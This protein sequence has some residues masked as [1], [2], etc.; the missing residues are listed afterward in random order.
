MTLKK[1]AVLTVAFVSAL[2]LL[3]VAATGFVNLG[4]ANPYIRD[5]K[6]EGTV[7]P[8]DGTK[9][10]AISISSPAN[11]TSY[12][13][14]NFLLNFSAT[15]ER[16]NNISLSLSE[17]YYKPSWQNDRTNIDFISLWVKNNYT[18]P[19]TFS[20]NMTN[21]PEGPHWLEVCAAATAFAYETRHE[22]KGVYY[23]TY[24][25]G[26][27]VSSSSVVEFTI[28]TI[29]PSILSLSVENKT[30]VASSV[31]L[32]L[33]TNEPVSQA[34]Y[35]LDG[36][37][38]VT[39]AGNTT[40]TN[41][42]YG[43]HNVTVYATDNAGNIGASET[44]TFTTVE[45]ELEPFPVVPVAAASAAAVAVVGAGLLVYFKKRNRQR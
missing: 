11:H 10:P 29:A 6:M 4:Q 31:P 22:V 23:T 20:I 30:Y 19:S 13:S 9:P 17:L 15:I 35:S 38:N 1:K 37:A 7:P 5:S 16:S 45:P 21:V 12:P 39:V 34:S 8:P 27:K 36:L 32:T 41:L 44:T 33:T 26:Y 25:V 42:P 18:Y 2:L 3:A 40:L 28:D 43:E 24:Y 14:I